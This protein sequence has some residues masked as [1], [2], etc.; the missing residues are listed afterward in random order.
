METRLTR[1]EKAIEIQLKP[2]VL[3]V[4]DESHKHAGHLGHEDG[5]VETHYNVFIVSDAFNGVSRLERHRMVKDAVKN[6]F[7]NG[8]HSLTVKTFTNG[9]FTAKG[10]RVE[11]E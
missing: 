1:I 2:D 10:R 11:S 6:E 3:E 8:L 9:E 5:A 7:A 4:T